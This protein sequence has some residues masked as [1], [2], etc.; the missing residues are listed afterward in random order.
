MELMSAS[1]SPLPTPLPAI[2]VAIAEGAVDQMQPQLLVSLVATTMPAS[3]A[4]APTACGGTDSGKARGTSD[5]CDD[6]APPEK[7]ES[8]MLGPSSVSACNGPLLLLPLLNSRPVGSM[9]VKGTVPARV[10]PSSSRG[11][12]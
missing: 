5:E 8:S 9:W 1:L 2:P 7:M 6:K 4:A 3:C 12:V 11:K 10:H